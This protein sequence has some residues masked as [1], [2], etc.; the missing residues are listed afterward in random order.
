LDWCKN[1]IEKKRNNTHTHTHTHIYENCN[2]WLTNFVMVTE[3]ANR[4]MKQITVYVH[5]AGAELMYWTERMMR[6]KVAYCT[7]L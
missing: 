4:V 2:F 5:E 7:F 6:L 1:P 3:M